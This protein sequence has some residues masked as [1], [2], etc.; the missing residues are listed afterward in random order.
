MMSRNLWRKNKAFTVFIAILI[1]TACH[2]K[3]PIEQTTSEEIRDNELFSYASNNSKDTVKLKIPNYPLR[4]DK[5]LDV[6]I[7]EIGDARVVL[8]GEATHGTHEFYTWRAAI[9]KRLIREK[10]F[11]F[12]AV[13]GDWPDCYR[14]NRYIKGYSDAGE[15]IEDV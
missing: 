11:R 9:S 6:L 10:G 7:K 8:L 2:N 12:I 14:I 4:N 13:E 15:S 1:I 3:R 5:D